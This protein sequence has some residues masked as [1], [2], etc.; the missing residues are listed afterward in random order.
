MATRIP[1]EMLAVIAYGPKDY[2]LQ[3]RKTPRAEARSSSCR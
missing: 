2:K 3:K 1:D